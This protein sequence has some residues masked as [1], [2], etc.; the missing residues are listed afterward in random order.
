[1]SVHWPPKHVSAYDEI[2]SRI[3]LYFGEAGVVLHGSMAMNLYFPLSLWIAAGDMDVYVSKEDVATQWTS[4]MRSFTGYGLQCMLVSKTPAVQVYRVTV[5]GVYSVDISA[6]PKAELERL[7]VMLTERRKA[8]VAGSG[9]GP[10]PDAG[11]VSVP[12]KLRVLHPKEITR[13]MVLLCEAERHKSVDKRVAKH[14]IQFQRWIHAES[15]GVLREAPGLLYFDPTESPEV[16][17]ALEGRQPNKVVAAAAAR[18]QIQAMRTVLENARACMDL[19]MRDVSRWQEILVQQV[20]ERGKQRDAAMAGLNA[21]VSAFAGDELRHRENFTE[22]VDKSA[23]AKETTSRQLEACEMLLGSTLAD[24]ATSSSDYDTPQRSISQGLA[25]VYIQWLTQRG[26]PFLK[27]CVA[28][29]ATGKIQTFGDLLK[30]MVKETLDEVL[31][32]RAGEKDGELRAKDDAVDAPVFSSVPLHLT[33]GLTVRTTTHHLHPRSRD[34]LED[35]ALNNLVVQ[36]IVPM[37]THVRDLNAAARATK[38]VV[39]KIHNAAK[40]LQDSQTKQRN[41]LFR[42]VKELKLESKKSEKA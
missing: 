34:D 1:M 2:L 42:F 28:K 11:E 19:H 33:D 7:P 16:A 29:Y 4:F 41:T 35:A 5:D 23:A 38:T 3:S 26:S 17:R 13:R 27:E 37:M 8:T 15:V 12:I 10:G 39:S 14:V 32:I 30:S 6:I 18:E 9:S 25:A 31:K 24:D 21:V 40:E 20:T 36:M 22:F